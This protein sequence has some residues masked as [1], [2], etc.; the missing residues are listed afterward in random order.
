MGWGSG[1]SLM[2]KIQLGMK[3]AEVSDDI[4]EIMYK[5]LIPAMEDQDWDTQADCIG[6]DP[7]F[8]QVLKEL[9][10]EWEEVCDICYG[11][12]EIH[13]ADFSDGDSDQQMYLMQDT[14]RPCPKCSKDNDETV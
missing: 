11:E 6:Y 12:G 8:D 14:L 3:N 7:V 1:S 9:H 13:D 10:P 4:R 2:D 5:I